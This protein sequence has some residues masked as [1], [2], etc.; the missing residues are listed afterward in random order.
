[1][2]PHSTHFYSV[3]TADEAA[4]LNVKPNAPVSFT[5][6]CA[7]VRA[8]SYKQQRERNARFEHLR[9]L[10]CKPAE[11]PAIEPKAPATP[12]WAARRRQL[13][14]SIAAEAP[15]STRCTCR[16]RV[17]NHR[18][19]VCLDDTCSP[20]V[21]GAGDPEQLRAAYAAGE[22]VV[23]CPDCYADR[24]LDDCPATHHWRS[25]EEPD[26]YTV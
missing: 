11:S 17:R 21:W 20:K 19:W 18:E 7:V 26:S 25:L 4:W 15:A 9:N 23:D 8:E 2:T 3:L 13:L 22:D 16:C 12:D 14:N 1:M 10:L 5:D 24:I 6:R